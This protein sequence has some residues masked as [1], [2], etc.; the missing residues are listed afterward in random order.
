[1]G[2]ELEIDRKDED[3]E[4]QRNLISAL[5][6]IASNHIF[7]EHDGSLNYGFEIITQPH[8]LDEFNKIEWDK[9]LAACRQYGYLSHDSGTCGLH[10]HFSRNLLGSTEKK[11]NNAIS[12]ILYFYDKFWS[13]I[14]LASRRTHSQAE[15][16][17]YKLSV[18]NKKAVQ[19]TVKAKSGSR[20][21]AVNNT[22]CETVE[23][24]L[25]RG[26]LKTE[27]FFAWI[28]LN[29]TI[30]KNSRIV[31][32]TDI[33]NISLWLKGL[34]SPTQQYLQS[35]NAFSEVALCA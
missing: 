31:K 35:K 14:L 2:I 10:I 11:Q 33:D 9:I 18:E 34:K 13:D 32:W 16:W 30:V 1:M 7:F 28:D 3:K 26:T 20:Y 8:T 12:K 29:L 21:C 6:S 27:T 15:R 22:N 23:F 4:S 19:K 25:G 17:A 24:R 5:T